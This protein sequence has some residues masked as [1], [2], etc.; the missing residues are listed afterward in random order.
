M[1]TK[2]K[3]LIATISFI[4]VAPLLGLGAYFA[5][6]GAVSRRKAEAR[7]LEVQRQIKD[8]E[9]RERFQAEQEKAR[10]AKAEDE[11]HKS[12]KRISALERLEAKT[13]DGIQS[14]SS[15]QSIDTPVAKLVGPIRFN[16]TSEAEPILKRDVLVPMKNLFFVKTKCESIDYV[17]TRITTSA[18]GTQPPKWNEEW[19]VYGCGKQLSFEI[20]FQGTK[21]S[22]TDFYIS[23]T[24]V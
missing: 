2:D 8:I 15:I 6:D 5:W 22:G 16:G 17:L 4:V 1:I 14:P 23:P 18:K 7:R 10:R 13:E 3:Y 9:D 24:R 21:P 19:T 20:F 11:L 12:V